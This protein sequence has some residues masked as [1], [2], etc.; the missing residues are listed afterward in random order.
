MPTASATT[1]PT[2]AHVVS[3]PKKHSII[4]TPLPGEEVD[5]RVF[6]GTAEIAMFPGDLPDDPASVFEPDA[7]VPLRFVRF[8]PPRLEQTAEGL[9]LSL[10][11]IRLDRALE[12][13]I[14]DRL[15]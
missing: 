3:R 2:I 11:H 14:G 8:R 13:L 1:P 12:F 5:G 9:T 10:P 7:R 6:D 15:A 4:G